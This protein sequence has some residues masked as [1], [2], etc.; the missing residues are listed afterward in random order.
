MIYLV[1]RYVRG[2]TPCFFQ[3]EAGAPALFCENIKGKEGY[4]EQHTEEN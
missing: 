2:V 3:I 4:H 1:V